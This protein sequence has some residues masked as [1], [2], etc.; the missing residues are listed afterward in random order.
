MGTDLRERFHRLMFMA[1][2]IAQCA[3]ASA[4]AWIVAKDLLGHSRPFFAPI[5]VVICIGIALGQRLRRVGELVVGVSVGVGVGD[6]LISQI[7]SGPWQLAIVVALAMSAAVLLDSGSLIG[8]QAGSSAVL[9]ATL[10]PPSGTGGLDRMIDALIGG[11]LAVAAVALLPASPVAIARRHASAVLDALATALDGTADALDKHDPDRAE[12]VLE[13]ARGT[14][15]AVE[16]FRTAL[17]MGR[18]IATISPLRRRQRH[19]LARYEEAS[20][21][22]DHALRNTRVLTR[23]AI[24]ALS[25]AETTPPSFSPSLRALAAATS[26]LRD[27]LAA[28]KDPAGARTAILEVADGLGGDLADRAGFSGDVMTA[29]LRSIVVDLLQATGADRETAIAALPQHA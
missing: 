3:V 28:G 13:E 2:T 20:V 7:G 21:P 17:K 1:P 15:S 12:E 11:A 22:V 23:R 26:L 8:L 4:S 18:E 19:E 6:L 10:L 14:Q 27:E 24:V 9:V 29:Q 25:G 16:E 5:A